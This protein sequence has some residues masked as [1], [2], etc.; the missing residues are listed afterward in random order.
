M[1]KYI[2]LT[3]PVGTNTFLQEKLS[4]LGISIYE[5][6]SISIEENILTD[7]EIAYI[8]DIKSFD[9]II[10]TS[11]NGVHALMKKLIALDMNN[12]DLIGIKIGVIGPATAN[13]AKEYGLKI[14]FRPSIYISSQ[15]PK[16]IE[17]IRNKKILL[18]RANIASNELEYSLA[19][20]GATV[21]NIPIYNTNNNLGI[22]KVFA[23]LL[24][25]DKISYI[26]FT[27]SSTVKGFMKRIEK[28][29]MNRIL[30]IPAVCIRPI[31]ANTARE[32]GFHTI[33]ISKEYTM[34]G[35]FNTLFDLNNNNE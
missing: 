4:S 5:M 10:F 33:F 16:E 3:R 22:D 23:K 21:I 26:T 2:V 25:E 9:W 17:D 27:S 7:K 34:K 18:P 13:V 29:T 14:A 20:K 1:P 31:T 11:A 12:D 19:K 35:I 8:K 28:E 30:S 15:I 32:I 6:P 24:N